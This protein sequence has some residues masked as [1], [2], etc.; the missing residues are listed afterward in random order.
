MLQFLD[1]ACIECSTEALY[2]VLQS[3]L[4]NALAAG[5]LYC[6]YRLEH[7][8]YRLEYGIYWP[9]IAPHILVGGG[10]PDGSLFT[11]KRGT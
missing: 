1:S 6:T 3:F 8:S 11:A 2:G 4:F 9:S 5:M 7:D 10:F